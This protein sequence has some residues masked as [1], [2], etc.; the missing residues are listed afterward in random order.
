[1]IYDKNKFKNLFLKKHFKFIKHAKALL[2]FWKSKAIEFMK[3]NYLLKHFFSQLFYLEIVRILKITNIYRLNSVKKIK[4]SILGFNLE[5]KQLLSLN[6]V[7]TNI[8]FTS[9]QMI[10][11]KIFLRWSAIVFKNSVYSFANKINNFLKTKISSQRRLRINLYKLEFKLSDLAKKSFYNKLKNDKLIKVLKRLLK[12][13][14]ALRFY[15]QRW[16]EYFSKYDEAA[17]RI[18]GVLKC[19]HSRKKAKQLNISQ[20]KE[21]FFRYILKHNLEKLSLIKQSVFTRWNYFSI[22]FQ[23]DNVI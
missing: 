16:I 3:N 6:K 10:L 11:R 2:E 22:V 21:S 9:N 14:I 5:K 4:R 1:M 13:G 20:K 23:L 8:Y 18:T 7:L 17:N 12:S 19:S 15:Y